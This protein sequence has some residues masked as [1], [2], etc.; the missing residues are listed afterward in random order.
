LRAS[1][2]QSSG[3][4]G[5]SAIL[6]RWKPAKSAGMTSPKRKKPWRPTPGLLT[7]GAVLTM[8]LVC[9][10]GVLA[11]ADVLRKKPLSTLRAE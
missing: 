3:P 1:C 5:V 2:P 6:D 10:I 11:S 7:I 9:T 8:L 4:A